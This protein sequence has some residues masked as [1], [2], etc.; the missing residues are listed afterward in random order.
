MIKIK[1]KEDNV[2]FSVDANNLI[3][4]DFVYANLFQADFKN[5]ILLN[6]NFRNANLEEANLQ[7]AKLVHADLTNA[8]LRNCN[9]KNADLRFARISNA[10]FTGADLTGAIF[11]TG[12]SMKKIIVKKQKVTIDS[13]VNTCRV[14]SRMLKKSNFPLSKK[15]TDFI[16]TEGYK[17]FR[18]KKLIPLPFVAIQYHI[19][20]NHNC[21]KIRSQ[22][23]VNK[24]CDML[25]E[26][27]YSIEEFDN[28]KVIK[29][30]KI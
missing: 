27:G 19:N 16:F 7:N 24:V 26:I 17:I 3:F 6:A 4:A 29:C 14:I 25:K 23:Q 9:L 1:N 15:I 28:M 2:I 13:A 10:D 5:R 21:D 20:K 11:F 18:V 22:E 30:K 8:N 12:F